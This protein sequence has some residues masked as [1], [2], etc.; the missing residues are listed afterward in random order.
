MFLFPTSFPFQFL[1]VWTRF[2]SYLLRTYAMLVA[3]CFLLSRLLLI[4]RDKVSWYV[5]TFFHVVIGC[6]IVIPSYYMS[7]MGES[8]AECPPDGPCAPSAW[9]SG[10]EFVADAHVSDFN[11]NNARSDDIVLGMP[12]SPI[13]TV[14]VVVERTQ[15]GA[16][17][18]GSN[19]EYDS[20]ASQSVGV[21]ADRKQSK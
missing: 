17:M 4:Q 2:R 21:T 19:F 3:L 18:S 11:A 6:S 7:V 14:S 16:S 15:Y 8:V 13:V 1:H 5:D 9:R 12:P 10:L 20:G